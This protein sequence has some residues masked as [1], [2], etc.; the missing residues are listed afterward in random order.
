M[1]LFLLYLFWTNNDVLLIYLANLCIF[2]SFCFMKVAVMLSGIEILK[3][4]IFSLWIMDLMSHSVLYL[5][6]VLWG[7]NLPCWT[8]CSQLRFPF[9]CN[10]LVSSV[11]FSSFSLFEGCLLETAEAWTY[12]VQLYEKISSWL[13]LFT[14]IGISY[15]VNLCIDVEFAEDFQIH[16]S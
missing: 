6:S 7:L 13:S 15:L 14:Y 11:Y 10:C 1:C 16:A 4:A 9:V 2:W 12:F 3:T 5:W 8:L